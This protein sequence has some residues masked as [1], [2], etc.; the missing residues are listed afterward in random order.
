MKHTPTFLIAGTCAAGC[1][2]LTAALKQHPQIYL[3]ENH[4]PEPHYFYKSWEYEKPFDYYLDKYFSG[5]TT[6]T[7]IGE[8]SGSYL[9]GAEVAARIKKHLPQVKLIFTLRNPIERTYANYR[10][11][12]FHGLEHLTFEEALQQ[13]NQRV[14]ALQG[15]WKEIQHI[16]YTGRSFYYNQLLEFFKYFS[17]DQILL[18]KSEETRIDPMKSFKRCYNFLNVDANF[19]PVLPPLYT[20]RSVKDLALQMEIRQHF[21]EKFDLIIDLIE[22]GADPAIHCSSP[23]DERYYELLANNLMAGAAP[24]S[25]AARSHLHALFEPELKNLTS[26]LPYAINDWA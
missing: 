21:K 24:M 8:T 18:L 7:A 17:A 16:N 22:K 15:I 3:P 13:E 25:N 4:R 19:E 23:E 9:F 5:V 20:S 11:T 6:E 26:I 10:A 12:A 2:Q 1:S 14:Q